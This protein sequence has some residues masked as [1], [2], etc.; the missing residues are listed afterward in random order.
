M[1]SIRRGGWMF[2][3]FC[4]VDAI[5]LGNCCKFAPIIFNLYVE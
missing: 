1:T 5:L 2:L 4:G 3:F